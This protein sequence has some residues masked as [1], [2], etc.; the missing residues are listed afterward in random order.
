MLLMRLTTVNKI[1]RYTGGLLALIV[2]IQRTFTETRHGKSLCKL[3]RE[4]QPR[5]FSC[6]G[7]HSLPPR[8][9]YLPGLQEEHGG[10]SSYSGQQEQSLLQSR[11]RTVSTTGQLPTFQLFIA[12]NI[13]FTD[14]RLRKVYQLPALS[15]LN[16]LVHGVLI[17]IIIQKILFHLRR[18]RQSYCSQK[19]RN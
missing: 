19:R 4:Y 7:R 6:S 14:G 11:L 10:E 17:E 15:I 13:H 16:F 9:L 18:V 12:H 3:W 1:S 5:R 2:D 8:L